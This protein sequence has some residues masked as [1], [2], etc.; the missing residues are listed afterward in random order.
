MNNKALQIS[1]SWIGRISKAFAYI[2]CFFI[3]VIAV[4]LLCEIV[5]RYIL[6]RSLVWTYPIATIANVIVGFGALAYAE[7]KDSHISVNIFLDFLKEQGKNVWKIVTT[8]ISLLFVIVF[9]IWA[10]IS[11]LNSLAIREVSFGVWTPAIYPVKLFMAVCLILLGIQLF[12]KLINLIHKSRTQPKPNYR[13]LIIMGSFFI[14]FLAIAVQLLFVSFPVG[15]FFLMV[16]L[17]LFGV[18][19][20]VSMG[21][22]A[23]TGLYF[24]DGFAHFLSPPLVSYSALSNYILVCM[25]MFVLAGL[26][27]ER[28]GAIHRIYDLFK[29]W[30]G[31]MPGSAGAVTISSSALFS[32]ISASSMTTALTIGVI[33]YPELKE[34][35]Y[36][37]SFASAIIAAGGTLGPL[38]PPSGTLII[39]AM[40]TGE[41]LGRLFL[42]GLFP[43]IALGIC[44]LVYVYFRARATMQTTEVPSYTW[45]QRGVSV[46]HA[47]PALGFPII[48]LG[49]IYFGIC[50][51]VECSAIGL[52]YAVLLM[53]LR[54][55]RSWKDFGISALE[56]SRFVGAVA[57]IFAGAMSVGVP[58]NLMHIPEALINLFNASNLSAGGLIILIWVLFFI[59]GMIMESISMMIVFTPFLFPLI[60]A[61]GISPIWYGVFMV[62]CIEC[63]CLT[64]PVGMLLFV[65]QMVTGIKFTEIV[66]GIWPFILIITIFVV[67]M[68]FFPQIVLW[69]PALIRGD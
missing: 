4:A 9:S 28:T 35:R 15:I 50:T 13:R 20:Y 58:I 62:L 59:M 54:N 39:Y 44:Y 16:L 55:W 42:A 51:A 65:V 6:G 18:P 32:A 37:P 7:N 63:A 40:L 52:L 45:R 11:A 36:K 30:I 38:I 66:R 31:K 27:L 21:L 2:A 10:S 14:I 67:I 17:I 53:F 43:G 26:L 12:I 60:L 29:Y 69:L 49:G 19:I 3:V 46:V 22:V 8:I 68:W 23:Y 57:A 48:V 41:S 5:S 47:L 56:T 34:Q 25:P 64:P 61:A 1:E 33:A 24:K